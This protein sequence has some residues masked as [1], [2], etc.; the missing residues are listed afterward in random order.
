MRWAAIGSSAVRAAEA[1][2]SGTMP[3]APS[4]MT[5]CPWEN[6][7]R[8][9]LPRE[10]PWPGRSWRPPSVS[11]ASRPRDRVERRRA[12]P[13]APARP[14]WRPHPRGAARRASSRSAAR[15][16]SASDRAWRPRRRGRRSPVRRPGTARPRARRA[17]ATGRSPGSGRDGS[18]SKLEWSGTPPSRPGRQDHPCAG[19]RSTSWQSRRSARTPWRWPTRSMRMSGSGSIDG[20]PPRAWHG[21]IASWTKPRSGTSPIRRSMRPT[22]TRSPSRTS[23][24]TAPP[25]RRVAPSSPDPPRRP[26]E[27]DH[28]DPCR[29]GRTGGSSTDPASRDPLSTASGLRLSVNLAS[30][31]RRLCGDGGALSPRRPASTGPPDTRRP[32]SVRCGVAAAPRAALGASA[33]T[34][35]AGGPSAARRPP[36]RIAT[37]WAWATPSSGS[38]VATIGPRP[39]AARR[40]TRSSARGRLPRSRLAGG[41]SITT[42]PHHLRRR[43]GDRRGVAPI[44]RDALARRPRQ[45]GGPHRLQRGARRRLV[46]PRRAGEGT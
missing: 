14:A 2:A 26:G 20:R 35:S 30:L 44:A 5:P 33:V 11:T 27:V 34:T 40:R 8:P 9:R 3:D 43:A 21:A 37:R 4:T 24:D 29:P 17:P 7:Q 16:P 22:G 32:R 31:G 25:A 6:T 46:A 42:A 12:R 36:A 1:R 13:G 38:R 28:D 15:R 45:A 18:G 10:R 23:G 19:F 39:C 41:S